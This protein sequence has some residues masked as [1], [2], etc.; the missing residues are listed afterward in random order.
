[1]GELEYITTL[2]KRYVPFQFFHKLVTDIIFLL[3]A[4]GYHITHDDFYFNYYMKTYFKYFNL[5]YPTSATK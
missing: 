3:K 5:N 4:E 1:M 2:L